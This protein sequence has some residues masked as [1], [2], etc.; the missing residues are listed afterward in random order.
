MAGGS[1]FEATSHLVDWWGIGR[2]S[3]RVL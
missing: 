2:N 3:D 1:H